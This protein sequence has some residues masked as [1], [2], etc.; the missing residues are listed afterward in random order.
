MDGDR[1]FFARKVT[2]I[3]YSQGK[4]SQLVRDGPTVRSE[5]QKLELEVSSRRL[6]LLAGGSSVIGR[7]E[8]VA[9]RRPSAWQGVSRP[10]Q[11]SMSLVAGAELARLFLYCNH[12]AAAFLL[13]LP[14]LSSSPLPRRLLSSLPIPFHSL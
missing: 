12:L 9:G 8:R 13:L 10:D 5:R 2:Y 4:Q 6:P 7:P 11:M 14:S 1:V 3:F